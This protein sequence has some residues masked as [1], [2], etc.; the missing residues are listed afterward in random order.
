MFRVKYHLTVN[1]AMQWAYVD[2]LCH[3]TTIRGHCKH[4]V[5]LYSQ[6]GKSGRQSG[7]SCSMKRNQTFVCEACHTSRNSLPVG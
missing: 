6:S 7:K 2:H 1:F 4:L 3:H 5:S